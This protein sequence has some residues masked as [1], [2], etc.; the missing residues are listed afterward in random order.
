MNSK[1]RIV[2]FSARQG[3]EDL[4]KLFGLV[5]GNSQSKIALEVRNS[6]KI[7]NSIETRNSIEMSGVST[8]STEFEITS[9]EIP[10]ETAISVS[11]QIL[12]SIRSRVTG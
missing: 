1:A 5:N 2:H 11:G 8:Y 9:K 12:D 3:G 4:D 6:V 7:R 10:L